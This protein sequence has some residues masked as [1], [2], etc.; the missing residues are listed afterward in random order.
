MHILNQT[1][2]NYLKGFRKIS[3]FTVV[4]Y[5]LCLIIISMDIILK[6]NIQPVKGEKLVKYSGQWSMI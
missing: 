4:I 6:V 5:H 1:L 3:G 2:Q